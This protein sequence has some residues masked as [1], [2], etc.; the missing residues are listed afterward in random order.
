MR[1]VRKA[2]LFFLYADRFTEAFAQIAAARVRLRAEGELPKSLGETKHFTRRL[3]QTYD[4]VMAWVRLFL[5]NHGLATLLS[6]GIKAQLTPNGVEGELKVQKLTNT[7]TRTRC[8]AKGSST[9][10][11]DKRFGDAKAS[12]GCFRSSARVPVLPGNA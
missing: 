5:F 8:S 9:R 3:A 6:I 11:S 2:P 7:R 10:R 4:I 12:P 1:F